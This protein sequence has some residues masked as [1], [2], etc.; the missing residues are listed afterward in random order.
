MGAVSYTVERAP[1]AD[2]PWT[3]AGA[4]IDE[5]F[6]QYRPLFNDE[7]A[8]EGNWYY[9]VRAKNDAGHSEPSNVVGPVVVTHATLVDELADF[10]KV[11]ARQG[12]IRIATRDCRR[13]KE[14]A[15]RAAGDAGDAL[16]YQL[17]T[18]IDGFRIFTFFPHDVADLKCSISDDGRTYRE[19]TA[20]KDVYFSG[21][22]DY[23]FWEPVLYHA[24]NFGG[25]ARF[26]KIE[27]TGVTQIGRV[28]IT[29]ALGKN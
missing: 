16:I 14:D 5:S 1:K 27:L 17:P 24:G 15:H 29:H 3:V 12:Q 8:P 6:V 18:S 10:S 2:G 19:I 20:S 23:G 4:N 26:L 21:A 11:H 9:R 7:S 28:E 22:G 13:A 25:N